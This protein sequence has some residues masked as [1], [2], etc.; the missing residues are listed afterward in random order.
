MDTGDGDQAVVGNGELIRRHRRRCPGCG[1]TTAG[2]GRDY[3]GRAQRLDPGAVKVYVDQ[4]FERG[5]GDAPVGPYGSPK[6]H[7]CYR[8]HRRALRALEVYA[9]TPCGR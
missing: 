5:D 3:W 7:T 6:T 4:R 2:L 8:L 9:D 1:R